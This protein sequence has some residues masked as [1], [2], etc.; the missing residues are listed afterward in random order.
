MDKKLLVIFG[1]TGDLATKKILPALKNIHTNIEIV[2]YS[3]KESAA[4]YKSIIGNF[5][6][7][8]PLKKYIDE[9]KYNKVYFYFAIPPTLYLSLIKIL[10]KT[11]SNIEIKIAL[12]K[13]FGTSHNEAVVLS[14]F[15]KEYGEENFYLV[16]HYMAKEAIINLQKNREDIISDD[17]ES[18]EIQILESEMLDKR[19]AFFDKVGIVNDTVQNHML[20]M[21]KTL[22]NEDIDENNFKVIPDSIVLDQFPSYK[23]I[24][25]VNPE[26]KTSTS[27]KGHFLYK[28]ITFKLFSAKAQEK[29]EKNIKINFKNKGSHTIN[30]DKTSPNGKLPYEHIIEDFTNDTKRFSIS[31]SDALAQ[32]RIVKSITN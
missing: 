1:A 25:G 5:E 31:V 2:T 13:P 18:V 15:I 30:I 23:S 20:L 19:G 29:N 17:I 14:D 4:G 21:V 27:F 16:D 11:F 10:T 24:E 32:W 12:E 22:L 7:V 28:D 26:S 9:D 3:R 6:D 8:N